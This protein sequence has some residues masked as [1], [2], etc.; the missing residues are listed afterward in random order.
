MTEHTDLVYDGLSLIASRH[1]R[2]ACL[3][4]PVLRNVLAQ[5]LLAV[6]QAPFSRTVQPWWVTVVTG[7]TWTR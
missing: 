4:R 2:R 5:V 3:D 6:G 7:S 1:R